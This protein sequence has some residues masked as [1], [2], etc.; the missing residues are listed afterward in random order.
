VAPDRR[1][2]LADVS[3]RH[4]AV[5]D[6]V[7]RRVL[8]VLRSGR[9][10]GGPVV[11]ELEA[12]I[13][14]QLATTW[15]VGCNSG[16]DALVLALK[17]LGIGPGDRVAVPALSFFATT[18]AVLLVGA[19]PVF[20]D[21][22]ADRPLLDPTGVPADV[23][24]VIPVHLF[25]ALSPVPS[26]VP[27]VSD[28][29]QVAGWGHGRPPG[30]LATLSFYPSKNLG[31]AGDAGAIVGDDPA[32]QARL[33][34]LRSHGEAPR[35]VHRALGW[36]SRLDAVQAAVL[37]GHLD[38]LDR[39][40]ARRRAIAARYEQALGHLGPLPRD[41]RDAVHQFILRTDGRD[42]LRNHLDSR[43]VDTGVYYPL[44]MDA[45]PLFTGAAE[46]SPADSACPNA[47][48]Y[49]ER[50]VALPCHAG[51]DAADVERVIAAVSEW[52][53]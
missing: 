22:L 51:L 16:T 26:G 35:S 9:Y 7:E 31:A 17:A 14:G 24:A 19:E 21:V 42:A 52:A 40:V 45:Q 34:S 23:A 4:A 37:L 33:C 46:P 13:A 27:I 29:A 11:A 3:G 1:L 5:A 30:V 28:A 50:C 43:G 12:A 39:R 15:G 32:L 18:S 25:G 47:R 49:C 48:R 41:P 6:A 8:S 38:D 10:V 2:G 36:N 20:C 44:P 53:P